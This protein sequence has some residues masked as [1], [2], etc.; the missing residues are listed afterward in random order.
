MAPRVYDTAYIYVIGHDV[1]P[2]KVGYSVNPR[3]RISGIR[4]DSGM[5]VVV[6]SAFPI[7]WQW[8]GH[9]ERMAHWLLRHK[10]FRN[11]WFN[12]SP[13]EAAEAAKLATSMHYDGADY[14]PTVTRPNA[15]YDE[16]ITL[17]L[18]KGTFARIEEA[19]GNRDR[20]D[21]I[22]AAIDAACEKAKSER[23]ERQRGE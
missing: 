4:N 20:A 23:R 5:A 19:V 16:Q 12:C 6:Q 9:A 8:A 18:L 13:A 15:L 22:R 21:F 11:E 2:Q 3:S 17:R 7:A 1:G 10:H 14:I